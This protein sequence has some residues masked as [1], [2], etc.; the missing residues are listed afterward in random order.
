M[1]AGGICSRLTEYEAQPPLAVLTRSRPLSEQ[2][3]YMNPCP[4]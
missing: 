4:G 1:A 2:T 3:G